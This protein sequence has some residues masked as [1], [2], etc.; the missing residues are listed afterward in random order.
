MAASNFASLLGKR[1]T[2]LRYRARAELIAKNIGRVLFDIES[3]TYVK[4][5]RK[6]RDGS[7]TYDRT[8]DLSGPHGVFLFGVVPQYDAR[9]GQAFLKT[10]AALKV[11]GEVG[12]YM[13]YSGDNYYRLGPEHPSNPWFITTLWVAAHQIRSART[14]EELLRAYELLE[15]VRHKASGSGM[16]SEQL[17]PYTGSHL[18]TSP[19]IWSHAE[20]VS[21]VY[22]YQKKFR[23]LGS[24]GV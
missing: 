1:D 21:T 4:L 17:N 5:V 11:P 22:L 7:L 3:G 6:E 14:R 12:G 8:L 10:A 20:Y 23:A 18:S 9:A 15:W 16:L 2:A 19:L 24:R 13:R